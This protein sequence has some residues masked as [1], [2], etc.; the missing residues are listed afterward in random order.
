MPIS[1][2]PEPSNAVDLSE[3]TKT[4]KVITVPDNA[5]AKTATVNFTPGVYTIS[6]T[7]TT[8]ATISFYDSSYTLIG[9]STTTSGSVIVNL[10]T[11]ATRVLC[12]INTGTNIAINFVVTGATVTTASGTLDSISASGSY[13]V[14]NTCLAYLVAVGGGAGG[15][16]GESG[17][18]GGDGAPS[19]GV[20]NLGPVI[21]AAGTYTAT[22]G[23][24]SA[25]IGISGPWNASGSTTLTLNGTTIISADGVANGY[26]TPTGG[27]N[28]GNRSAGNGGSSAATPTL[29]KSVAGSGATTGGGGGG[30][31][32]G[33]NGGQGGGNSGLGRGGNAGS[34]GTAFGGGGG[35]GNRGG[36]GS[37]GAAGGI[38]VMRYFG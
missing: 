31:D 15:K 14:A 28:G 1:V 19:G 5:T 33:F 23:N 17:Y 8:V 2:F 21:L 32:N 27:G 24:G 38:L 3:I 6:C 16:S 37:P 10:A 12:S 25:A 36:G 18:Y 26:S 34:A 7:S 9:T 29:L 22:I 30:Q 4:Q 13:V 35:G 11:T 20:T